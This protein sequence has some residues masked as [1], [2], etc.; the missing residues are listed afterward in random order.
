[1]E[2]IDGHSLEEFQPRLPYVLPEVSALILIEILSALE[3]AHSQNII[4]RDL[5]PANIL[6]S[7][8]GR[9]LVSDFGLAKMADVSRLTL[10]GTI[11]GSPAYMAPEQARGDITT[12]RSDLFSAAAILYFLV[13][14][15]RAFARST[16]LASLAAVSDCQYE[17]AQRRNPKLSAALAT[18]IHRGLSKAPEDRYPTAADFKAALI[19]HLEDL[20]LQRSWFSFP[21]WTRNPTEVSI[22]ALQCISDRLTM[23]CEEKIHQGLWNEAMETLSHLG[24]VAPESGAIPRLMLSIEKSRRRA[25]LLRW[26]IPAAAV[27]VATLGATAWVITRSRAIDTAPTAAT[28]ATTV[29]TRSAAQTVPSPLP[30]T[31]LTDTQ[32]GTVRFDIPEDVQVLWNGKPINPKQLLVDQRLGKHKLELIKAGF[33][34]IKQ[35]VTVAAHEPTVIRVR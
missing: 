11:L 30:E 28:P 25:R 33:P 5:K 23:R 3:H 1:M 29:V 2:Y 19:Q 35:T 8:E 7:K 15:T 32:K 6:I 24:Q 31:A 9:V 17:P 14:G 18:L 22:H 4:H 20:G 13:T 27:S 10:S 12:P 34:P 21:E 16:P 26:S